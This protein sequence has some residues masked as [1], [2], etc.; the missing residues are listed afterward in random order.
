VDTPEGQI[1]YYEEGS[2]KP[3]LLIHMTP[4][5]ST[6]YRRFIPELARTRRVI[7]MDTLGFG[8]S[9]PP[10]ASYRQLGDYAQSVV[11]FL[12]AMNIPKADMLSAF[13][14]SFIATET[15]IQFPQRVGSLVLFPVVM[16]LTPE[17]RAGRIEEAKRLAWITPKADGSHVLDALKFAYGR[18]IEKG[19]FLENVD[20]EY[21]NDWILDAVKAGPEVTNIALKVYHYVS[22]P[23]LALVKAPTLV[24]GL[25]GEIKPWYNTPDRTRKI[26][27]L[28]SGSRFV[29]LEGPDADFRVWYTRPKE[30]AELIVP[31]LDA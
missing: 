16:W 24:I 29:V 18:Y 8:Q 12:D 13:T 11:H 14:G 15:A 6:M 30:L 10:P 28:I 19:D 1:H 7:A 23:R 5:S 2:G 9:D 22:E 3:L 26:H 20:F 27:E 31:F 17:E 4:R 21:M 25:N